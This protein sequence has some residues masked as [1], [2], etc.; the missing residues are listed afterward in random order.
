[1]KL[2]DNNDNC[3]NYTCCSLDD[4]EDA[5]SVCRNIGIPHYVFN[6]KDCFTENVISRFIEAYEQGLTPNPCIDCN[7]FIKIQKTIFSC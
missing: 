2:F 3:S 1:M 4:V 6:Y 7:R 5:R